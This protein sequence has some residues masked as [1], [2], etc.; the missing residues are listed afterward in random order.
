MPIS[1]ALIEPIGQARITSLVYPTEHVVRG[2]VNQ[3]FV[4]NLRH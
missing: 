2:S 1:T 3:M 4:L